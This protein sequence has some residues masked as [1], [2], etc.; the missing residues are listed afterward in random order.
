[1]TY[2]TG[3][4]YL[5]QIRS[6]ISDLCTVCWRPVCQTAAGD[7]RSRVEVRRWNKTHRPCFVIC[8]D[9]CYLSFHFYF[10]VYST[11]S[12]I[13]TVQCTPHC[14]RMLYSFI[15]VLQCL[16]KQKLIQQLHCGVNTPQTTLW[17]HVLLSK[18]AALSRQHHNHTNRANVCWLS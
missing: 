9:D 15:H 2:Y 8:S 17:F 10:V 18:H 16:S 12:I 14:I 13:H 11:N 7:E 5:W 6:I 4:Y 3:N 1:M